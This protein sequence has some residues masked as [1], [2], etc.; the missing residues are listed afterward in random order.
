M[1]EADCVTGRPPISHS[2]SNPHGPVM[3]LSHRILLAA[4]AFAMLLATMLGAYG[5]HGLQG[6]LTANAWSAYQTAVQYQFIHALGLI[7]TILIARSYPSSRLIALSS[8][9]LLIGIV[10]FCGSIYATSFGA[11][12]SFG[13]LAPYGGSAFTLGWLALGIGALRA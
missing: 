3:I 9:L 2:H 5:A 6:S 4:A 7:A 1:G 8:W 11:P 10:L 12:A 13:A